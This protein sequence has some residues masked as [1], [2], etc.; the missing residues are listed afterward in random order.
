MKEFKAKVSYGLLIP[1]LILLLGAVL[2]PILQQAPMSRILLMAS[3][4]LPVMAM[5][6]YLFLSTNYRIT[7]DGQLLITS[8]FLYKHTVDISKITS[9][10]ATRNP[11]AGPAPSLDRLEVKYEKWNSVVVSPQDKLAFIKALQLVNPQVEY[12]GK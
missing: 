7:E 4:M 10:T 2:L 6:L 8:G 11:I 9:V 5:V 12:L 1:V 3:I